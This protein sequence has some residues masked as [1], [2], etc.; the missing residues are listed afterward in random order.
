MSSH[1]SHT[2]SYTHAP[3]LHTLFPNY[4]GCVPRVCSLMSGEHRKKPT[5]SNLSPDELF[6][7]VCLFMFGCWQDVCFS[8]DM[9]TLLR[10]GR[11]IC[12]GERRE[13]ISAWLRHTNCVILKID[14]SHAWWADTGEIRSV[15]GE[16]HSSGSKS[17]ILQIPLLLAWLQFTLCLRLF[18]LC[19]NFK[20]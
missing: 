14:C 4:Y 9:F 5:L 6:A 10:S 8:P 2:H 13:I 3:Q 11:M 17:R 15:A 19:L 7:Q 12:I 18:F 20:T 16:G 1:H